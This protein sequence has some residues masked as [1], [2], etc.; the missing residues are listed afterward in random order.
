MVITV[1]FS[2][3]NNRHMLIGNIVEFYILFI[4]KE[5]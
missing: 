2:K 5:K 4:V 1:L 3:I